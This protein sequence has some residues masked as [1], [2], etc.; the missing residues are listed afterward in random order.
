MFYVWI[1]KIIFRKL[2]VLFIITYIQYYVESYFLS[3][4][5]RGRVLW[6]DYIN[7]PRPT[8]VASSSYWVGFV[9]V[10][11]CL[12]K[13]RL[14]N[15]PTFRDI[16]HKNTKKSIKVLKIQKKSKKL[17]KITWNKLT[18]VCEFVIVQRGHSERN[19]KLVTLLEE[20]K[21]RILTFYCIIIFAAVVKYK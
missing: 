20:R 7:H 18:E 16:I 4:N 1:S 8:S 12:L 5:G 17:W 3:N 13:N 15:P 10:W 11:L 21:F 2:R 19:L 14:H 9:R 6:V